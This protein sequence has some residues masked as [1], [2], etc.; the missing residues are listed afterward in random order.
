MGHRRCIDPQEL[1]P[2][3]TSA[4]N[5]TI[6]EPEIK[7]KQRTD[8]VSNL[9]LARPTEQVAKAVAAPRPVNRHARHLS[10]SVRLM[11]RTPIGPTGAAMEKPMMSPLIR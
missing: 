5:P 7:F 6:I 10:F 11:H 2:I 9:A 3:R 1:R 4:P 8:R